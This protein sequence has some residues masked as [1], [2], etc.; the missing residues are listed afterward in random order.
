MSFSTP[1]SFISKA[2]L[3]TYT[4][5]C[6][7]IQNRDGLVHAACECYRSVYEEYIRLGLL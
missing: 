6:V 3:I 5:G 7:K 1:T 4:R 2:G